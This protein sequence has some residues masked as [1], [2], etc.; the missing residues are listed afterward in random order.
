MRVRA[1]PGIISAWK[2]LFG[3][4]PTCASLESVEEGGADAGPVEAAESC[5]SAPA[6]AALE[7]GCAAGATADRFAQVE[8]CIVGLAGIVEGD[9]QLGVSTAERMRMMLGAWQCPALPPSQ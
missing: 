3:E 7:G 5:K 8:R 4:I 6:G 9:A 1:F 2:V